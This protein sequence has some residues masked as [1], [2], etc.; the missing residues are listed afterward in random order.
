MIYQILISIVI[1]HEVTGCEFGELTVSDGVCLSITRYPDNCKPTWTLWTNDVT[2]IMGLP[3]TRNNLEIWA[4]NKRLCY[5]RSSE[6]DVHKCPPAYFNNGRQ[7][8][9]YISEPTSFNRAIMYCGQSGCN[10]ARVAELTG[11]GF[12][13]AWA[14]IKRTVVWVDSTDDTTGLYVYTT[15]R[16]IQGHGIT[17]KID[18]TKSLSYVCACDYISVI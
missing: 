10:L 6:V 3:A 8:L 14:N 13:D 15:R 5:Y 17:K 1:V 16:S 7:C 11:F 18:K 12:V 9:S 2:N 4:K